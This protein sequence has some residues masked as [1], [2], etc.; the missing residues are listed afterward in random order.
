MVA[1]AN[2]VLTGG[3]FTLTTAGFMENVVVGFLVTALLGGKLEAAAAKTAMNGTLTKL[4]GQKFDIGSI[5]QRISVVETRISQQTNEA[6]YRR[7]D[8]AG[9]RQQ[10]TNDVTELSG[11]Q[12]FMGGSKMS[13]VADAMTTL[14]TEMISVVGSA[15]YVCNQIKRTSQNRT[16]LKEISTHLGQIS[17]TLTRLL[18]IG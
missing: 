3:D 7:S 13:T 15:Q 5:K 18:T 4:Y 11:I 8:I 6:T 9:L 17:Y 2:T 1:G 12:T 14:M 10:L 16:R